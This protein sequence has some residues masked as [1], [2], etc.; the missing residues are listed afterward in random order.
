MI[1]FELWAGFSAAI[2]LSGILAFFVLAPFV[3]SKRVGD[4][5]FIFPFFMVLIGSVSGLI[6]SMVMVRVFL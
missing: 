4:W 3:I 2:F 1:N 6:Q 5:L